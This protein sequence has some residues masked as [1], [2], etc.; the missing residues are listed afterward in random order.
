MS[1]VSVYRLRRVVSLYEREAAASMPMTEILDKVGVRTDAIQDPDALVEL[2][3]EAAVVE[4]ACKALNDKTFAARVGLAAEGPGTL[5]AYLVRSSQ[6]VGE[7]LGLAQRFYVFQ[8]PDT[9][10]TLQMTGEIA[11]IS[12]SSAIIPARQY[13]RH[14][15]LLIFGLYRRLRQI[16]GSGLWPLSIRLETDDA[17]HCQELSLLAG[18]PVRGAQQVYALRMPKNGLNYQIPTAD[19]ALLEHL[20][21]HGE[22]KL[23]ARPDALRGLSDRIAA[24]ISE[25]LPGHIPTGD[26]VASELGMTRRTMTRRLSVEGTNFKTLVET[27]RCDL[28]KRLMASGES[29]A[30]I[31]FLLD[32][33]DQAAFSV[34]F[35]RW[36]GTSPARYRKAL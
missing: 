19:P 15:E 16:A 5:V 20:R 31:A 14:R 30:Q 1:K 7:A 35:K 12:L 4:A 17:D 24:L 29:L 3:H 26:E 25:H 23:R 18:C 9:T 32:F 6:T 13:P 33:A 21:S 11:E 2:L 34:A 27:A 22:E 36:T 10:M 28:A 8:D